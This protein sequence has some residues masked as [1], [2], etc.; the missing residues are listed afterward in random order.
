[1]EDL[2][3]LAESCRRYE[4][5]P[6]D[7]ETDT[8]AQARWLAFGGK[9]QLWRAANQVGKSR[10]QAKKALH[11][12][13]R[14]GPFADRPPG[15]VR[16]LVISI[17]KEQMEPLHAKFWELLPKDEVD[18]SVNFRPGFG[19]VG[20]PARVVFDRGPGAGS[21]IMFATY[22]QGANRI[23]GGTWDVIILDEPPPE[24]MWSAVTSRLLHG[25]P[26]EL[27][28][29]FTATPQSPDLTYL[30]QKVDAGEVREMQTSLS[31]DAVTRTDGVRL[32]S[33][34]KVD[35]FVAACLPIERDMRVHGGWDIVQTER[36]LPGWGSH[37]IEDTP[38]PPGATL[39]VGLDHGTG[40]GKQAAALVAVYQP[41]R[42]LHPRVWVLEEYRA[43][44]FSTPEMDAIGIL[45]MLTRRGFTYD[46]VDKWWGDRA[47]G[48]DKHDIAKSNKLIKVELARLMGRRDSDPRMKRIEVPYKRAGSVLWGFRMLNA[49]MARGAT[50]GNPHFRVASHL[51][52]FPL[53]AGKWRG[54]SKSPLKDI[55]DAVRYPVESEVRVGAWFP[56][57]DYKL[58]TS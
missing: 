45:E 41:E 24:E 22:S 40:A 53:A 16:I 51:T 2:D 55:L 34:A 57:H 31:V 50:D 42:E 15:P 10:A 47:T 58:F 39:C 17:S 14:T 21:L 33:Q 29:T 5:A 43:D 27:W 3:L 25:R 37:C 4:V 13:R 26:G 35:A 7:Y 18:R 49:M 54:E 12:I 48:M 19:F 52:E 9:L 46:D 36:Y 56:F 44:G 11:M 1:M 20:K 28:I 38:P 6:L 8:D 23:E 30:R 32:L